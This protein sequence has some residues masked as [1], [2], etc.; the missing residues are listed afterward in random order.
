MLKSASTNKT[1]SSSVALL[2]LRLGS[3]T[4]A[5]MVA[6]LDKTPPAPEMP[7][8]V[9]DETSDRYVQAYER[10][11]GRSFDDYLADMGAK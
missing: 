9:T 8:E 3:V 4:D 6:V 1:V 5:E 10:L 7:A 2:L 11:T